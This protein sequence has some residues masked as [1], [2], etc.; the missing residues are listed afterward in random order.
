MTEKNLNDQEIWIDD[1]SELETDEYTSEQIEE[2]NAFYDSSMN[3]IKRGEVV[4]GKIINISPIGGC[5]RY[6]IQK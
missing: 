5:S 3:D 4:D 6:R 1:I 2:M